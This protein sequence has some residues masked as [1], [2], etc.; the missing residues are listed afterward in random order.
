MGR[1]DPSIF[2]EDYQVRYLEQQDIPTV[3]ALMRGNEQYYRYCGGDAVPTEQGIRRD[4]A[5]TPPGTSLKDKYYVGFFKNGRLA[6]IMDLIDGYPDDDTAF[7]GF[8]MMCRD[9]QGTGVGSRMVSHL[10]GVLRAEGCHRVRLGIDEGN[11]QSTHFWQKNGF[12]T[13]RRVPQEKGVILLAER[14]L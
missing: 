14:S 6:A 5:L 4:M 11:P 1:W 9:C 10:C 13:I 7:I 3:L 8:F 2:S 12:R